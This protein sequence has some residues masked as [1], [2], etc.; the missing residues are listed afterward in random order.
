MDSPLLF[1][2]SH[3]ANAHWFVFL[4]LLL[5]GCNLPI[6]I[7]LLVVASALL[8]VHYVP[9]NTILLYS[10]LLMGC[11]ISAWIS[12]ALGRKFGPALKNWSLFH[13]ILSDKKISK[14]QIFYQKH[15]IYTFIIGRFIP[16]GVRNCLFMTSGLSR[17]SF[18]RFA[19]LDFFACFLW[20][21]TFFFSVRHL[22]QNFSVIWPIIKTLNLFIFLIFL[23]ALIGLIW[24]KRTRKNNRKS[25]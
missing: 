15:G 24:Y 8:S 11:C 7:D 18:L 14:M 21:T 3:A 6:S 9:E 20:L 19:C 23:V 22:G 5:A 13:P 10:T 12:Y 16:F 2:S 17:L 1:L 4:G 25:L